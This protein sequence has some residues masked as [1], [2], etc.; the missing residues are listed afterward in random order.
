[1]AKYETLDGKSLDVVIDSDSYLENVKKNKLKA[2]DVVAYAVTCQ[3][4][5]T[6]SQGK[7]KEN[8][9][10]YPLVPY[11]T[12]LDGKRNFMQ[13]LANIYTA[14]NVPGVGEISLRKGK[15]VDKDGF[16]KLINWM[17]ESEN[18]LIELGSSGRIYLS[19]Q[20][21]NGKVVRT[22]GIAGEA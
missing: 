21:G 9:D 4:A 2:R 19:G 12:F 22:P 13:V 10:P 17:T 18:A 1:M 8:G 5:L 20:T 15:S 7:V 3:Q 11:W 14:I 6:T 16:I